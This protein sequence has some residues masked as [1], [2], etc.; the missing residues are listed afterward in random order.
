MTRVPNYQNRALLAPLIQQL[1]PYMSEEAAVWVAQLLIV[2][3]VELLITQERSSKFADYRPPWKGRGHVI[4]LNYNLRPLSFLLIFL[5]EYAHLLNWVDYG[6]RVAIH[7]A[8]WAKAYASLVNGAIQRGFFPKAMHGPLRKAMRNPQASG[9]AQAE[10]ME[11][12]RKYEG[13][14]EGWYP[15]EQLKEGTRFRTKAGMTFL[16]G[17][18]GRTRYRC[19]RLPGRE[20]YLIHQS[21]MV[22]PLQG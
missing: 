5:H 22:M 21:L 11:W 18:K 8:E 17:P 16:R 20:T 3:G 9:C 12:L 4:T 1:K 19:L 14:E 2:H 6:P 15:L 10:M 13:Q 7:G